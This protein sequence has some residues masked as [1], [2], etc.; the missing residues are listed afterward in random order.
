MNQVTD[1]EIKE[2]LFKDN[3]RLVGF[4]R[5]LQATGSVTMEDWAYSRFKNLLDCLGINAAEGKEYTVDF[6]CYA[7]RYY[8]PNHPEEVKR[9]AIA[10]LSTAER[11]ALGV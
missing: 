5:K 3:E 7:K 8:L 1:A 11:K 6:G 10:K 4:L 9:V 2:A